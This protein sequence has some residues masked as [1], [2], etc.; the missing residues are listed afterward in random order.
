VDQVAL[1]DGLAGK[2]AWVRQTGQP[3]VTMEPPQ[4]F[5][6]GSNL[7][8]VVD[9][10]QLERLDPEK[11]K[12]LWICTTGNEP[13]GSGQFA[14]GNEAVYYA[15]RKGVYARRITDGRALWVLP[16]GPLSCPWRILLLGQH[17]LAFPS[18]IPRK[19]HWSPV[20]E[21]PALSFPFFDPQVMHFPFMVQVRDFP[22]VICQLA[23]GKMVQ[24]MRLTAEGLRAGVQIID[25]GVVV[26]A[27]NRAWGFRGKSGGGADK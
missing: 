20:Y 2:N 18:E 11:G 24:Q 8:L 13:V 5:W 4:A 25:Q 16:L 1:F 17:L 10:W 27:G 23:D 14:F 3:S 7:Y 6:D 19:G 22:V 12:T 15:T 26:G 21:K 9:G